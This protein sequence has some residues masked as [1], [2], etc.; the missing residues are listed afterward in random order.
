MSRLRTLVVDDNSD[1]LDTAA[2]LVREH[3]SCDLCGVARSGAEALQLV[4][5]QMPDLVLLDVQL[6]DMSG[7]LVASAV[8]AALPE[9]RVLMMSL[10]DEPAYRNRSREIG[11]GGFLA[12][13]EFLEQFGLLVGSLAAGC[14]N[15]SP[16][17]QSTAR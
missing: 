4:W 15:D 9:C 14:R 11:A 7:F 3:P 5:Q 10:D 2:T 12:K 16:T 17:C 6:G 8:L 1:F 13:S